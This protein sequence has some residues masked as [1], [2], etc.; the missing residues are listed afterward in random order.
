MFSTVCSACTVDGFVRWYSPKN[1]PN[2]RIKP[3]LSRLDR[4]ELYMFS[5]FTHIVHRYILH[6][7]KTY[8]VA[9]APTTTDT[10][11]MQIFWLFFR[12]VQYNTDLFFNVLFVLILLDVLM[13]ISWQIN[14]SKYY[15]PPGEPTRDYSN[16]LASHH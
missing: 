1:N 14:V 9:S 16:C 11:F 6:R 7:N 2:L 5:F 4:M 3:S 13:I 15:S 8:T 10:V 12:A